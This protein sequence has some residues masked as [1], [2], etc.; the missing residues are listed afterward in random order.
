MLQGI[1]VL[2]GIAEKYRDHESRTEKIETAM[3]DWLIDGLEKHGVTLG[4]ERCLELLHSDIKLNT[5]GIE[6]WLDR[7]RVR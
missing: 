1:D 3:S 4:N 2:V 6:I 7:D 5:Q